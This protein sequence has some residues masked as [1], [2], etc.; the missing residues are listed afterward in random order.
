M[1]STIVTKNSS[2]ASAV[3]V[4]GDLTQGELAVNVTDKRLFT[5]NSGGTVVELG[6]NPASL[7]LPNGT[8]NGV[9]YLNGSKVV[10]TG[11]ALV[12]DGTYF[13]ANG[14]RIGGSDASNTIYKGSG[15][16]GITCD[17]PS[18]NIGAN[19]VGG[20]TTFGIASAEQMRLTSTGL[21]IGTSSPQSRLE[22]RQDQSGAITRVIVNNN[23]ANTGAGG[24]F[25]YYFGT[26]RLGGLTHAFATS[27]YLGFDVWSGSAATERMRLD[28]SGNLGLGVTPSTWSQGKAFE[29]SAVGEG[30]WGNGLGD[31]WMI[32]GAYFNSGFKYSGSTKATAYR[33]GAGTTDGSHSWHVAGSGTAGNPITFTQAMTLDSSGNLLVGTTSQFYSSKLNVYSSGASFPGSSGI[34]LGY[35]TSSGQYRQ[36]YINNAN[37]NMYFWNGSNEAYLTSAGAWTNASDARLKNSIVDIKHGLSSVMNTKPRSYKMNDLEGDYIGFVAQEL[38]TV[39]PEV[40]SG[41]PERQLGVDYGSLVAVAFKAIQEQQAI[42]EQLKADVAALK[43][44]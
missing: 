6:T 5:K 41:D 29:I 23:F 37:Q 31:I 2:T 42:I 43:G 10:T 25:D 22:A 9:A 4:S 7:A 44:N 8:A 24:S 17:G 19:A 15:A 28:S 35:G 1:A 33:Q 34:G 11:S 38:Q 40:V 12:F 27:A 21:G 32:N 26:T 18:I 3:P 14:L 16:L 39:I 13:N 30:L 20:Y 36:M